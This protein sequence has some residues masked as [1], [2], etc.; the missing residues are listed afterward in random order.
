MFVV[1]LVLLVCILLPSSLPSV[2]ILPHFYYKERS[3]LVIDGRNLDKHQSRTIT[4]AG[5]SEV[6]ARRHC[7]GN[8]GL[9]GNTMGTFLPNASS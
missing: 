4:E 8:G 6:A 7:F 9:S 5:V 3:A 1:S 2:F